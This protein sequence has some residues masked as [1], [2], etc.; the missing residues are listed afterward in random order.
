MAEISPFNVLQQIRHHR[1]DQADAHGINC[2]GDNDEGEGQGFVHAKDPRLMR[3]VRLPA[4]NRLR[5][6]QIA[7]AVRRRADVPHRG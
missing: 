2:Q 4:K 3:Y 1:N 6:V 7:L 5:A